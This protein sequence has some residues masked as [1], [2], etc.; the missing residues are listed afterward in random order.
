MVGGP[1]FGGQQYVIIK[2]KKQ[3][4]R[5]DSLLVKTSEKTIFKIAY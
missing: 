2:E 3:G 4:M 5:T 1:S